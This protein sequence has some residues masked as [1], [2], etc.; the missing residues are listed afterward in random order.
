M[1][2]GYACINE[3]L[4]AQGVKANRTAIKRTFKTKGVKHV[5]NLALLSSIDLLKILQWNEAHDIKVFRI[6]SGIFPWAS[7]YDIDTMPGIDA[8][9]RALRAAGDYARE[10]NHRISFHPGQFNCMASPNDAVVEN[11]LKDL[12]IHG[13]IMD[14]IGMPQ[15]REAKINIHIGGAYGDRAA[16]MDRFCRN[17]ERLSPSVLGR[18]T[19]EKDDKPSCYSTK[20]LYDGIFKRTGVPIVFDSH[21]FSLGPQDQSYD[22][23]IHMAASTWGTVRPTCHH[24]N[25][26]KQYE[27]EKAN[28]VSHSE[29]YYEPFDDRGLDVDVVLECK[30]KENA[31]L[32]YRR[33][34]GNEMISLA[35]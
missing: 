18:L 28:A 29:W 10:H 8:I 11:S 5:A 33:D 17:I 20:M 30:R 26:R 23:A 24:S 25:S 1:R 12:E 22:E 2:L 15:T 7:E 16:A 14:L 9:S 6:S 19:V 4:T 32:K 27:D 31:L 13:K 34:F 21:H 3:T 35:A